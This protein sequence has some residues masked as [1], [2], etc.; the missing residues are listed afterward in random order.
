MLMRYSFE[1]PRISPRILFHYTSYAMRIRALNATHTELILAGPGPMGRGG[2]GGGM[3]MPGGGGMMMMMPP[4][5]L[6]MSHMMQPMSGQGQSMG[7]GPMQG[8]MGMGNPMGG[9]GRGGR[10][11]YGGG[12]EH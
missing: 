8:V 5:A 4:Q 1:L 12:N 9:R 10:G 11:G 7:G 6:L 2:R 3:M